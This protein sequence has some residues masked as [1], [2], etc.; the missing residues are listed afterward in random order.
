MFFN[1]TNTNIVEMTVA[2]G[3]V[4]LK[5]LDARITRAIKNATFG[6]YTVGGKTKSNFNSVEEIEKKAK[7]DHQS[8]QDLISRRNNIKSAIVSSNAKAKVIVDNVEMTVAEAIERKTSIEY[9]KVLLLNMK[10]QYVDITSIVDDIND[11]VK[12]RLDN[13]LETLFGKEGKPSKQAVDDIS[14]AFNRDNE[15]K[16]IDP[17]SLKD[18]IDKLEE[19]IENFEMEVDHALNESNVMNKIKVSS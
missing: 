2:R 11:E 16:F 8:I 10:R 12:N 13:H 19:S 4:E 6:D 17:I 5:T 15:A 18:K 9:D 14:K 1:M 3:L 7:A